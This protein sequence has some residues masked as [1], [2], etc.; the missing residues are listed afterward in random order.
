MDWLSIFSG[1]IWMLTRVI[2][3]IIL[4]ILTIIG[5]IAAFYD[6]MTADKVK[7]VWKKDKRK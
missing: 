1:V 6:L 5:G 3:P 4:A 7:D 2:F